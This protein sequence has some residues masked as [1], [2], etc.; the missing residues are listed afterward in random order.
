M[1]ESWKSD[2]RLK[3]MDS[4]K[5]SLLSGFADN[6]AAAPNE[7]KMSIFLTLNRKAA[8]NDLHFSPAETD[9]LLSILTENMSPEE[10]AKVQ[11]I[12]NLASRMS[13]PPKRSK[14]TP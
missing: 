12:K 9:L 7:Q 1:N 4:R 5:L 2:P 10:K 8:E 14:H 3:D 11:M 6:L 13:G